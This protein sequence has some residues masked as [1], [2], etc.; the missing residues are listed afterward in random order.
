MISFSQN[1]VWSLR[2]EVLIASIELYLFIF[3][4]TQDYVITFFKIIRWKQTSKINQIFA[5]KHKFSESNAELSTHYWIVCLCSKYVC[6]Y[7]FM[8]N[9][10]FRNMFNPKTVKIKNFN[11]FICKAIQGAPTTAYSSRFITYAPSFIFLGEL[12]L[13]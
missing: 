1:F 5:Y 2:L 4:I 6:F 9:K 13:K 7:V 12:F 3:K 11:I 10:F 8:S